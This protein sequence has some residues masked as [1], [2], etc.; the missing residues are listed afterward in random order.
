[1]PLDCTLFLL[2]GFLAE[3]VF[4]FSVSLR[5]V[6]ET[7]ALVRL[8]V[9]A[10]LVIALDEKIDAPFDFSGRTLPTAAEILIVFDLELADVLFDL[11]KIFVNGRHV[12]RESPEPPC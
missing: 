3:D 9:P 6:V 4:V 12:A 11:A 10:T 7:E 2:L 1:M 5:E 8:H